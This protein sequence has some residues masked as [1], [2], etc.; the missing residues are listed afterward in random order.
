MP[1]SL[2][3]LTLAGALLALGAVVGLALWPSLRRHLTYPG[4]HLTPEEGDPARWGLP[5]A[6]EVRI[7]TTDGVTLHGWWI[8][9]AGPTDDPAC[10]TVIYFHGNANTIAPRAWL[11]RRLAGRGLNVLLFDYRGYGLSEGRPREDGLRRDARAAWAHVVERRV[12]EPER[13]I[14]FGH[15]LGSAVALEL[16][17]S[18]DD[19]RAP[20]AVVLGAP[21][22]DFPTLFRHHAPWLPFSWLPWR[23]G[24]YDAG[25]RIGQLGVPVLLLVGEADRVVPP[26]ASRAVYHDAA[27]PR[28]LV[29]TDAD[30][31]TLIAHPAVWRALDALIDERLGCT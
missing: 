2:Q 21:F 25:S 28:R 24:R 3:L 7:P 19:D 26:A 23:E 9:A 5:D 1:R 13:V 20:A 16:A 22:P 29:S 30:H 11:G 12:A 8:P 10:G 4:G 27:E 6:E 18:L 15:S 17:L 31:A 14:L